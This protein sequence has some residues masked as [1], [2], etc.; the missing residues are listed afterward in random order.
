MYDK[1]RVSGTVYTGR[2]TSW[3]GKVALA[4]LSDYGYAAGSGSAD[5]TWVVRSSGYVNNYSDAFNA[6]GVTPVLSLSS[7][8]D[9][10]SGTGTSSS[11][12]QLSV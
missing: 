1:E 8:L 12:Y 2:P 9:I 4:Y 10:G 6:Y 3:T 7:E 11:P 5:D